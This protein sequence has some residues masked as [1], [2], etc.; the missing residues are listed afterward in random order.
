MKYIKL[1]VYCPLG[2]ECKALA[3]KGYSSQIA[4]NEDHIFVPYA[5]CQAFTYDYTLEIPFLQHDCKLH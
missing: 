2:K 3:D 4:C 5:K 1:G